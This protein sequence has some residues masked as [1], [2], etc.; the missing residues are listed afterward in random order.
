MPS[1][2]PRYDTPAY[3]ESRAKAFNRF[4]GHCVSCGGVAEQAHH[5]AR[6]Y[7]PA[8]TETVD[9]SSPPLY[10]L[11]LH[12]DGTA[13][14]RRRSH[15]LHILKRTIERSIAECCTKLGSKERQL[16]YPPRG[17]RDRLRNRHQPRNLEGRSQESLSTN[18][19]EN[20]RLRDLETIKAL[21]LE[22]DQPA[23]PTAGNPVLHRDRAQ[24]EQNG[25]AV[26]EGLWVLETK[27][28]F[29]KKRYGRTL[30]KIAKTAQFTVPVVRSTRPILRTRAK[31]DPPWSVTVRIDTDPDLVDEE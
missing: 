26:R 17:N 30:E 25:G 27:F 22:E 2:D 28:D 16:C 12:R 10:V 4:R 29:D 15:E 7:P 23:I 5:W 31:F 21:W 8:N 1:R 19:V 11:P 9:D 3:R 24:E 6:Q 14:V 20:A 18:C 13:E